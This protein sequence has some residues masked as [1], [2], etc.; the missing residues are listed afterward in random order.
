[1]FAILSFNTSA[2]YANEEFCSKID[3]L[4]GLNDADISEIQSLVER[5][6]NDIFE[7]VDNLNKGVENLPNNW[8]K[9]SIA[10]RFADCYFQG[11]AV[12]KNIEKAKLFLK[13]ASSLGS[14]QAT[15][16][17][18]SIQL[19]KSTD[20]K[21]QQEGFKTL[22][23]EFNSGSA[24]AAGKLGWAYQH[25]FGVKKDLTKAIELYHHAAESGMT[26]WQ[27]LLAH[28]YENG[29]LNLE[30]SNA[31]ALHWL[32]FEPKVH[33]ARYECWVVVYYEDGTFPA[34]DSEYKKNN[35][36]CNASERE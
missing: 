3:E 32:N 33:V 26:S 9:Q 8:L 19:F 27:F 6:F 2:Q 15:H 29:Y 21:E 7:A 35:K 1:M 20:F 36:L 11:I 12:N 17:L 24:F 18:A 25:G 16:R 28:A 5:Y 34:N 13:I 14:D 4:K 30:K 10:L 23:K 31:K 22:E